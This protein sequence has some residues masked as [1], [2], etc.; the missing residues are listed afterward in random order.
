MSGE[1]KHE[2][3]DGGLAMAAESEVAAQIV[4]L[5]CQHPRGIW[6]LVDAGGPARSGDVV[7]R[8]GD[9]QPVGY[10]RPAGGGAPDAP[11]GRP[12][13]PRRRRRSRGARR[14]RPYA[15]KLL[16]TAWT[17]TASISWPGTS[18]SSR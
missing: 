8:D 7:L 5:L 1:P 4:R 6:E 15:G 12:P 18:R 10:A 9:G 14:A 3:N 2:P 16:S 11:G 13:P 17:T